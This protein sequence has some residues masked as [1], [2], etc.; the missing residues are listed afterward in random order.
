MLK[1]KYQ[2]RLSEV[3]TWHSWSIEDRM[4][5]DMKHKILKKYLPTDIITIPCK[6]Q[7]KTIFS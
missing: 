3:A 6:D 1:S 5:K 7:I 4:F 2:C